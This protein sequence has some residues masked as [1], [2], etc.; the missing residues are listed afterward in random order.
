MR[1][2]TPP[3][4]WMLPLED[5]ALGVH[6]ESTSSRVQVKSP[7]FTPN[8]TSSTLLRVVTHPRIVP[9]LLLRLLVRLLDLLRL[10]QPVQVLLRGPLPRQLLQLCP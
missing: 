6:T 10:V 9:P 7:A 8:L 1:R 3:S 2:P 4:P 5:S